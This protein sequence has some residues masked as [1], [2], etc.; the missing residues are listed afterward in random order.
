MV[1]ADAKLLADAKLIFDALKSV[2]EMVKQAHLKKDEAKR[3]KEQAER[4]V[5]LATTEEQ[6]EY[7]AKPR[8]KKIDYVTGPAAIGRRAYKKAVSVRG[9]MP[10][11]KR[12]AVS[13]TI[14]QQRA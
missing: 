10:A 1:H 6:D 7:I 2:Y 8:R 11:R 13:K 4:I 12:K 14:R 5:R 3:I 9:Q